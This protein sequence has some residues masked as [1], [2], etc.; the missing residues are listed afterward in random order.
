MSLDPDCCAQLT[1][2]AQ[3]IRLV[4]ALSLFTM[5]AV[6]TAQLSGVAFA[7]L[8]PPALLAAWLLVRVTGGQKKVK[9][10]GITMR[11]VR[12]ERCLCDPA[13]GSGKG[14]RGD[15]RR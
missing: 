7:W 10:R 9:Y 14:G 5:M 12:L 11:Q 3:R 8:L 1:R 2:K 13:A 6:A 15:E 4:V